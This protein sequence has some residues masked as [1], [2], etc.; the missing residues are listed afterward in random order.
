M[1][2]SQLVNSYSVV[3]GSLGG[4]PLP[5]D[6]AH[7]KPVKVRVRD[8]PVAGLTEV[9]FEYHNVDGARNATNGLRGCINTSNG[10]LLR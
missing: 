8:R 2:V 5:G 9:L 6:Q 10:G 7:V 4:G 1:P 3:R